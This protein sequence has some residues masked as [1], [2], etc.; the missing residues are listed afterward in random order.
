MK[1]TRAA[2]TIIGEDGRASLRSHIAEVEKDKDTL[3]LAVNHGIEDY[4]LLL[5]GNEKLASECDKLKRR[6]EDL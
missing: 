6:C 3:Q 2:V 1:L 5:A 4:D